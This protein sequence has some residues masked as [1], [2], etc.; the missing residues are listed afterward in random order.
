MNDYIY[1]RV[2]TL[3]VLFRR[4]EGSQ[5]FLPIPRDQLH[6]WPSVDKVLYFVPK[7]SILGGHS[8][9]KNLKHPPSVICRDSNRKAE[10]RSIVAN[11][12]GKRRLG[13]LSRFK[14]ESK[15]SV[16]C[17][18]SNRK[19]KTR[20]IV[21]NQIGKRRL[22]QLSRPPF[23]RILCGAPATIEIL[24][25]E[26]LCLRWSCKIVCR[27]IPCKKSADL[28]HRHG[29]LC[30]YNIGT[31][32]RAQQNLSFLHKIPRP[33][34]SRKKIRPLFSTCYFS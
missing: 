18:D 2:N 15:N 27:K 22:G 25:L 7:S 13:Q 1:V 17:R 5:I 24:I 9:L 14:S 4:T 31:I 16:N 11:Q 23:C 20:S 21:A 29:N 26:R 10:T 12:I 8:V 30:T 6:H 33:E 3:E 34:I 28:H 19:A 32:F